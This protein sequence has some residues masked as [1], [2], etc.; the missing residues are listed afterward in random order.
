M[1]ARAIMPAD[2]RHRLAVAQ[3]FPDPI[4]PVIAISHGF[5]FCRIIGHSGCVLGGDYPIGIGLV[6]DTAHLF[7]LKML[8]GFV[9]VRRGHVGRESAPCCFHQLEGM[10]LPVR[11]GGEDLGVPRGFPRERQLESMLS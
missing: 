4:Q 10:F 11:E 1:V 9:I 7:G 3:Q 5:V 2:E 6:F 8:D